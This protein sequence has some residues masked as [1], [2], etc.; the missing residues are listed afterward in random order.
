MFIGDQH[1][2]A[3]EAINFY[4]SIFADSKVLRVD[5]HEEGASDPEGNDL[6]G[7]VKSA[8]FTIN[9]VEYMAM[10]SGMCHDFTFTPAISLFVECDSSDE[11][12]SALNNLIK[13]GEELMPLDDYGFSKQ[14]CWIKDRFGVT[15]Q[16][17]LSV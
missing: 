12:E 3:E 15:W 4:T 11:Q 7:T 14:F 16:L 17:N 9:G 5:Q 8:I 10:D 1:G 6:Q 2:K 13:D